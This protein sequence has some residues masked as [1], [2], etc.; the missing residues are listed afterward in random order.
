MSCVNLIKQLEIYSSRYSDTGVLPPTTP[1]SE[2]LDSYQYLIS[3]IEKVLDVTGQIAEFHDAFESDFV[4]YD[5]VIELLSSME[6]YNLHLN[7]SS[8]NTEATILCCLKAWRLYT[9]FLTACEP[10]SSRPMGYYENE[11]I[12]ELCWLGYELLFFLMKNKSLIP[13]TVSSQINMVSPYLVFMSNALQNRKPVFHL[14]HS[15]EIDERSTCVANLLHLLG[16]LVIVSL[17]DPSTPKNL[18]EWSE[19]LKTLDSLQHISLTPAPSVKPG[20]S[21]IDGFG[22]QLNDPFSSKINSTKKLGILECYSKIS[23]VASNLFSTSPPNTKRNACYPKYNDVL[24]LK[25]QIQRIFGKIDIMEYIQTL[26]TELITIEEMCKQLEYT[27]FAYLKKE[28]LDINDMTKQ[29]LQL[30]SILTDMVVNCNDDVAFRKLFTCHQHNYLQHR[31][32]QKHGIMALLTKAALDSESFIQQACKELV[33]IVLTTSLENVDVFD[34]NSVNQVSE[35]N[36]RHNTNV[37]KNSSIFANADVLLEALN[38]QPS[39]FFQTLSNSYH[40]CLTINKIFG[41]SSD[42]RFYLQ[43]VQFLRS[44]SSASASPSFSYPFSVHNAQPSPTLFWNKLIYNLTKHL[45]K[46]WFWVDGLNAAEK[47]MEY[48]NGP[49]ISQPL[50]DPFPDIQFQMSQFCGIEGAEELGKFSKVFGTAD[51]NFYSKNN[52]FYDQIHEFYD[53][54]KGSV[55]FEANKVKQN[56]QLYTTIPKLLV[57]LCDSIISSWGGNKFKNIDAKKIERNVTEKEE[58]DTN[59]ISAFCESHETYLTISSLFNVLYLA[60]LKND[61]FLEDLVVRAI[62]NIVFLF[63]GKGGSGGAVHVLLKFLDDAKDESLVLNR[64]VLYFE[65]FV[66]EHLDCDGA[67]NL[68]KSKT[69][70]KDGKSNNELLGLFGSEDVDGLQ[71]KQS[72]TSTE[73]IANTSSYFEQLVSQ[74][75]RKLKVSGTIEVEHRTTK[76]DVKEHD[77][78]NSGSPSGKMKEEEKPMDRKEKEQFKGV[79]TAPRS[80]L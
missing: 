65:R 38:S 13:K 26:I 43:T 71:P 75:A 37:A 15:L 12:Y 29:V 79:P 34:F 11:N 32:N 69:Q 57:V 10:N 48:S 35:L 54:S 49:L 61:M 4:V 18:Y 16:A 5:Q 77:M 33:R 17:V 78:K 67:G 36:T 52:K 21:S 62:K 8:K 51:D 41:F 6:V 58:E 3:S 44:S 72:N 60:T 66:K 42:P 27:L 47:N 80:L 24:D 39:S 73:F 7:A 55:S 1:N 50:V 20:S 59:P 9:Q 40:F 2:G 70:Q 76:P 63:A 30:E 23:V 53:D 22:N 45:I 74:L 28:Y 25:L 64:H 19:R 46:V 14:G 68:N 31:H 56:Q